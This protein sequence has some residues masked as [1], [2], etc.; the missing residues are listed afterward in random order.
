MNATEFGKKE[1][2]GDAFGT[3]LVRNALFAV[4]EARAAEDAGVGR[5]WLKNEL[6]AYWSQR[7]ALVEILRYFER[8]GH[9][10]EAWREDAETAGL[11][12]GAVEN[13]HA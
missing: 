11:V 10:S 12:A 9:T 3:S 8:M 7:K 1:L 2:G 13:D 5:N 4:R 6:P